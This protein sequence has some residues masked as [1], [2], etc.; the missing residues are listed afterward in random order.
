MGRSP[1]ALSLLTAIVCPGRVA[2]T[3]AATTAARSTAT[4]DSSRLETQSDRQSTMTVACGSIES[5]AAASSTGASTVCHLRGRSARW[6]AIRLPISSSNASA[7][8]TK[9]TGAP[10]AAAARTASADLP[11]RAP[12]TRKVRLTRP[13]QAWQAGDRGDRSEVDSPA[14]ADA[15]VV[16]VAHLDHLGDRV[17]DRDEFRCR[18]AT[19][20]D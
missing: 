1:S 20:Q 12:P 6:A 16:H 11:L 3:R 5:I 18:V 9:T 13:P 19:G 2:A 15:L 17:G 8:A 7:V 14:G 4:P 10:V